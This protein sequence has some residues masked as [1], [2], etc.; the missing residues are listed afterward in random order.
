MNVLFVSPYR[1][2]DGWGLVSRNYIKAL[3]SNK[4]IKL[5]TR[6]LYYTNSTHE[7]S[8]DIVECE[9]SRYEKYDIVLQKLLPHSLHI[10]KSTKNIAILNVE[11]GGWNNSRSILLLNKLDEIYVSTNQEKKWLEQSGIHTTIK[12]VSQPIDLDFLVSNQTKK[13]GLPPALQNTFNFYCIIDNEDRSNLA[14]IIRAFHLAFNETDR[15]GLVI[16]TDNSVLQTKDTRK[17]MQEHINNIKKELGISGIYKNELIINDYLDD[18]NM[19]GLH[20]ACD[21]FISL[22]SGDNFSTEVLSAMFLGKTP[23]V[24][25]NT[26]LS[27]IIDNSSGFIIKSEKTPVIMHPRPLP[28]DYD[29]YN[30]DEFWYKP[31]IYSLIENM[32]SAFNLS[33][34]KPEYL[35]KQSVG[36]NN[37]QMYSYSAI[38]SQLCN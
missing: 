23:M 13:I 3:L 33:K 6:P 2:N 5:T 26:G 15:V 31:M 35:A 32:R 9:N 24:M 18:T 17:K 28:S 8:D 38:G 22:K 34:N 19:V 30:S 20:N 14:T 27:S 10:S 7:V 11:T 12:N 1:Q 4:N 29:L 25:Q 37:I 36:R 21:C 16:K